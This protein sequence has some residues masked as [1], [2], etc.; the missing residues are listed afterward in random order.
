MKDDRNDDKKDDK[1]DRV[2]TFEGT[3]T[4]G[5]DEGGYYM[6]KS[7]YREQF[8]DKLGIDPVRGT[9]NIK[10][11]DES[12]SKFEELKDEE[13]IEIKGFEE[14]GERFGKIKAFPAEVADIE[15]AVV[16]P[17]LSRYEKI[18]EIISEYQLR[19]ELD[20]EDGDYLKVDIKF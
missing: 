10:L 8:I 14:G 13:G 16:I 12:I 15:C 5:M 18:M 4:A 3:V 2:I 9:L 11:E 20:L 7:G 6:S 19:E 1:N 17:A